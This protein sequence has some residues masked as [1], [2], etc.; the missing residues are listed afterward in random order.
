MFQKHILYLLGEAYSDMLIG[1]T[2]SRPSS[3]C[4]Y[5]FFAM[6]LQATMMYYM[7]LYHQVEIYK[8]T[9]LFTDA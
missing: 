6:I 1:I 7:F 9:P 5:L 3:V 2:L 4:K 8:I